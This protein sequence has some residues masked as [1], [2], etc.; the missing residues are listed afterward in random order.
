MIGFEDERY[1]W[2]IAEEG[3]LAAIGK[4]EKSAYPFPWT[5]EAFRNELIKPFSN[6][7]VLCDADYDSAVVAYIVYWMLFDECHVLNV[8]VDSTMRGKG[9]GARMMREATAEAR[10]KQLKRLFLEVRVSNAP[11]IALYKKLGFYVDHTK[12]NFYEDG[13]SAYFMILYLK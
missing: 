12:A 6:V 3:D 13:E 10:R 8:T 5:E 11:A 9:L 4:I 1:T 2:R 7:A